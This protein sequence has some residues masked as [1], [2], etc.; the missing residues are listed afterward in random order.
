M[1]DL[2]ADHIIQDIQRSVTY[3]P[4]LYN[5]VKQNI[6]RMIIL[7]DIDGL[8]SFLSSQLS[9]LNLPIT[10][11]GIHLH[12]FFAHLVFFFRCGV[13]VVT[14]S[15]IIAWRVNIAIA[16]EQ[17]GADTYISM[18][19]LRTARLE[20][21]R[22]TIHQAMLWCTSMSRVWLREAST[23]QCHTMLHSHSLV[24]TRIYSYDTI[25]P[26]RT[27]ICASSA[28]QLRPRWAI[29]NY[30]IMEMMARCCNSKTCISW[31]QAINS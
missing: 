21:Y 14:Q 31:L 10:S 24:T 18:S 9:T 16:A 12:R 8:V 23:I 20:W 1:P 17:N 26:S 19:D 2:K 28:L 11:P 3:L 15:I 30:D 4:T 6:H 27:T 7:N 25:W 13:E 29:G 5:T 22:P